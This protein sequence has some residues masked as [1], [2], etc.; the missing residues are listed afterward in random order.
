MLEEVHDDLLLGDAIIPRTIEFRS[1]NQMVHM[2]S[3]TT[4]GVHIDTTPISSLGSER[5][6]RLPYNL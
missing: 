4:R 5:S 1:L 2:C 3:P 6:Q